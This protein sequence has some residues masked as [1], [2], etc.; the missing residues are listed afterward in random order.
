MIALALLLAAAAPLPAAAPQPIA[1]AQD[2]AQ[3]D[4][5]VWQLDQVRVPTDTDPKKLEGLVPLHSLDA[6][7]DYLKKQGIHFERTR[8]GMLPDRLPEKVRADILALPQ[9]EPFILPEADFISIS[10]LIGRKLPP[11]AV[12]YRPRPSFPPAHKA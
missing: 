3:P 2:G 9:G 5:E 1:L 12:S 4:A 10:V 8:A 11:G 6:V 7:I